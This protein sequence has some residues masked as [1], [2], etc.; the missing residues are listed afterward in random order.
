MGY[1]RTFLHWS[2]NKTFDRYILVS[3]EQKRGKT[4]EQFLTILIQLAENCDFEC[5]CVNEARDVS[6]TNMSDTDVQRELLRD[7]V[8][9]ER[10]LSV[11][12]NM[13]LNQQNFVANK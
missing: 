10:A 1:D 5:H 4:K 7:T 13:K 8:E 11:A 12:I 6:F 3:G 9:S 2:R